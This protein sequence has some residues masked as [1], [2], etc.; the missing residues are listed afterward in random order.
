[1][2]Y[3]IFLLYQAEIN[4]I[5]L[6]VGGGTPIEGY[7]TLLEYLKNN[8]KPLYILLSYGPFHFEQADWFWTRNVRFDFL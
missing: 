5:N 4:S 8:K 1:M 6:S 7:Y 3:K 2:N